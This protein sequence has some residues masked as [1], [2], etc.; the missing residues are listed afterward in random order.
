MCS[1]VYGVV[2]NPLRPSSSIGCE[3]LTYGMKHI[4]TWVLDANNCWICT[5][6]S[7]GPDRV[8]NVNCAIFVPAQHS[9]RAPGDSCIVTGFPDGTLGMWIP[10][11][12]TQAGS[13]YALKRVYRAHALGPMMTMNDGSQQY[14]GVCC[15]QLCTR[16]GNKQSLLVSGG[17][18]GALRVRFSC[19]A[20]AKYGS[21][22]AWLVQWLVRYFFLQ[23][24]N[25]RA[26]AAKSRDGLPVRG[27]RLT[28]AQCQNMLCE[29]QPIDII[30]IE[31]PSLPGYNS[32]CPKIAGLDW[33]EA[34]E[35]QEFI[36]GT[37][38]CDLWVVPDTGRPYTILDGHSHGVF[39]VAPHPA[40]SRLFVTADESGNVLR[41]NST[42]RLLECRT[43][44]D[45]K[46]YAIAISS[47]VIFT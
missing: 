27:A 46:C 26:P 24:W 2:F 28:C 13:K 14:G 47:T 18:D 7:F 39:M 35:D 44:L 8:Q 25:I 22:L 30:S 23:R 10:P 32:V 6:G 36:T 34:K 17:A 20:A 16:A 4:K 21:L 41:Y 31:E 29:C 33:H 11:F 45:F 9:G 42:S 12:P 40:D 1:Q 37:S 19:R 5:A 43:I 15:L 38:G 3:Y